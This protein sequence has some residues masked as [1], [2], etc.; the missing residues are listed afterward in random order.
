[1]LYK[2]SNI[3]PLTAALRAAVARTAP[4]TTKQ[5]PA[6]ACADMV[7]ILMMKGGYSFAVAR[8]LGENAWQHFQKSGEFSKVYDFGALSI[9]VWSWKAEKVELHTGPRRD[10]GL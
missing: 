8:E 4:A 7:E 2:P 3:G 9:K 10:R 1:M 6:V 5:R